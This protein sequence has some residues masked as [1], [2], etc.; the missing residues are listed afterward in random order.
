MKKQIIRFWD[1]IIVVLLGI[2]G[3]FSACKSDTGE[4]EPYVGWDRPSHYPDSVMVAMYGVIQADFAIKGTVTDKNGKPIPSIQISRHTKDGH[5]SEILDYTGLNGQYVLNNY[6]LNKESVIY[7]RFE[8]I[9]GEENGGHFATK[10]IKV[11]ITDA[12]KEKIEK[13]KQDDGV[14]TKTQN[15]ELKS[16]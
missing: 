15:V 10:E 6:S 8:D 1:K 13:C 7:L 4:C 12:D 2:A 16:K 3:T 11:K 14:F 5:H 9:D